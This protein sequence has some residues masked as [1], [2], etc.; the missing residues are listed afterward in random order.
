MIAQEIKDKLAAMPRKERDEVV[1][2][3]FRLRQAEEGDYAVSVARRLQDK[4]SA[5]WLSP[6]E[7]EQRL[8]GKPAR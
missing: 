7:F 5:H 2:F 1:A 6:E 4:E 8:D 3:L